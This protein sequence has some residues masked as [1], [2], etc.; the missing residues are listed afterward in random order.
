MTPQVTAFDYVFPVVGGVRM[1]DGRGVGLGDVYGTAFSISEGLFLTN[2]HVLSGA[3]S[4]SEWGIGF[5]EKHIWKM[6]KV[7]RFEEFPHMDLALLQAN[8][9]AAKFA[10]WLALEQ[11]M[12]TEVQACGFP[13]A[14]DSTNSTLIVR[15]FRGT[16]VAS[17]TWSALHAKPRAYELSFSCPRGLSGSPVW[18]VNPPTTVAGVVFGNS[19]T[20]MI[21]YQSKETSQDGNE[22]LVYEKVEALHLGLAIQSGAILG[23]HSGLMGMPF[24]DFLSKRQLVEPVK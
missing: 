21:A 20:D 1:G 13:H 22:K 23:L 15:S 18:S 2:H 12:L 11:P 7:E 14:F 17:R 6:A 5:V 24:L 19:I 9:P 16:I 10:K 4:Q 8:V 3:S